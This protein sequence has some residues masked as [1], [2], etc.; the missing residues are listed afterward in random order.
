MSE[1]RPCPW[2][3]PGEEHRLNVELRLRRVEQANPHTY[4]ARVYCETCGCEG[5]WREANDQGVALERA[6]DS[7]NARG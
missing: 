1:L 2:Q 3:K 6:E 4:R 5:P 7:W